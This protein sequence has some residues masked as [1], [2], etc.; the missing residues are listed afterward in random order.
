MREE[1]FGPFRGTVVFLSMW[2]LMFIANHPETSW[3]GG[4]TAALWCYV[5]GTSLSVFMRGK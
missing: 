2:V 1:R 5:G 4:I 3:F